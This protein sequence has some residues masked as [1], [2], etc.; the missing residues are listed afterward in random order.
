MIILGRKD[1]QVKLRGLRIE[2]GEIEKCLT[3]I[4]GIRQATVVIRK[5]GKEDAICAYYTADTQMDVEALKAEMKKTLT[6]YMIP[7]S[8]NQMDEMPLTPNGKINFKALKE[9]VMAEKADKKM[10]KPVT[11][12]EKIFCRIFG[13][14]LNME[15][16]SATDSFFDLGGTSLT[17]TRVVIA[18][19]KEHYSISYGDVFANPTP[20]MLA[21]LVSTD[22]DSYGFEDLEAY[23][24]GPI[25]EVLQ[26]NTLENCRN[27]QKQE[28]GDVILTGATGF[29]GIHILCE[30]L[31]NYQG[32]VYCLLRGGEDA[33]AYNR[34]QT[35]FYYY[36]EERLEECY[37]DRI[38]VV[39]GDITNRASL[40][41][42]LLVHADTFINCAA[43][44][45]HFSKGTDIEDVNYHGVQNI[46]D[47]C[48]KTGIRLVHVSTMSIG[49]VFVDEPGEVKGQK[50]T[51]MN[52]AVLLQ[53]RFRS[54]RSVMVLNS[55]KALI[56][57]QR[58]LTVCN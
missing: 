45:K 27:G 25:E 46:L 34:L 49:G 16:V 22:E 40:D 8:F 23:D 41:N 39:N 9:P 51:R 26:K 20:R 47:F 37:A 1:N 3:N 18:A 17:A 55:C 44:V 58:F 36:F 31:K 19:D 15:E 50:D 2:L 4:S 42:L 7:A 56:K 30:L 14:I 10:T 28:I 54:N 48:E 12:A 29:L 13:E 11:A 21:K 24:Y 33:D 57:C 6:D 35:I 38:V 52:F 43:N 53:T 5:L 32:K